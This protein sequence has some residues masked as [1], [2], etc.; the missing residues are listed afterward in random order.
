M[1]NPISGLVIDPIKQELRSV[2]FAEDRLVLPEMHKLIGA[3]TLD[4][5]IISDLYDQIWV[6]GGGL[7]R[8]KP[9]HAFLLPPIQEAPYAGIAVL[10]GAD[11]RGLCV[12]VHWQTSLAI[13]RDIVWLGPIVP[14]VTWERSERGTRAVV[15]YRK[16]TPS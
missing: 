15:T 10:I 7:K 11:K 4:N 14:T 2:T 8:G 13:R 1:P 9:V 5:Q 3:E 6:D 16:V 12:S